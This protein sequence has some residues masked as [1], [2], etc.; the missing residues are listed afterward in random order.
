MYSKLLLDNSLECSFVTAV[1]NWP[2]EYMSIK[3]G[4]Y[5]IGQRFGPEIYLPVYY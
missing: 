4:E 2:M 5:W 1:H 3:R